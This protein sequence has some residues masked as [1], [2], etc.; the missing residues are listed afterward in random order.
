MRQVIIQD[1]DIKLNPEKS[2]CIVCALGLEH[3]NVDNFF[4]N[5]DNELKVKMSTG[6]MNR[7]QLVVELLDEYSKTELALVLENFICNRIK[8]MNGLSGGIKDVL[9][10][11]GIDPSELGMDIEPQEPKDPF[12]SIFNKLLDDED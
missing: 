7:S 1:G 4:Q 6:E 8:G 11:I 10:K 3:D 9:K 12:K 2:E 5:F